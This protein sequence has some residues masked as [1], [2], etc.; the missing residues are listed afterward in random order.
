MP[1]TDKIS[2]LKIAWQ[3]FIYIFSKLLIPSFLRRLDKK[4]R[5]HYPVAW[6]LLFHYIFWFS[7]ITFPLS[8]CLAFSLKQIGYDIITGLYY[9]ILLTTVV[10]SWYKAQVKIPAK[11]TSIFVSQVV[12]S[13]YLLEIILTISTVTMSGIYRFKSSSEMSISLDCFL[14]WNIAFY[15]ASVLFLMNYLSSRHVII[16][17]LTGSTTLL[18]ITNIISNIYNIDPSGDSSHP[19]L[20]LKFVSTVGWIIGCSYLIAFVLLIIWSNK[21]TTDKNSTFRSLLAGSFFI[22]LC[23]IYK[24]FFMYF[25]YSDINIQKN[26]IAIAFIP[27]VLTIP[28]HVLLATPAI[29]ILIR[30]KY[31]PN[32]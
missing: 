2:T 17:T 21:R 20:S 10:V 31:W 22:S 7:L 24:Y 32:P 6:S 4:L 19:A 13:F 30:H 8:H 29:K 3:R 18:I 25:K 1:Q 27:L 9:L 26:T 15:A 16:S 11:V 14:I 28:L 5:L 23:Y 12:F